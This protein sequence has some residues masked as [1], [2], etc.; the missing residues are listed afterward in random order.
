MKKKYFYC[1]D[2]LVLCF[3]VNLLLIGCQSD[4]SGSGFLPT[5]LLVG[6]MDASVS[7]ASF[8]ATNATSI[9][10]GSSVILKASI[11]QKKINH[12]SVS[13]SLI[14]PTSGI[15]PYSIDVSTDVTS[16][17]NYCMVSYP[18]GN[19]INYQAKKG[20]GSG[21]INITSLSPNIEGTFFG[22]LPHVSGS[23][24]VTI[25]FGKFKALLP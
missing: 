2:I 23:D 13:I 9:K 19:C 18:S 15:P 17:I 4:G 16:L 12:D 20:I 5:Q 11:L 6:E 8:Y 7:G 25:T 10:N 14:I 3:L 22:V 1:L 21:T 24:S